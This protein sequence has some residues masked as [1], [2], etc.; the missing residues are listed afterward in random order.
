MK[1]SSSPWFLALLL[2]AACATPVAED[3]TPAP[4]PALDPAVPAAVAEERITADAV[5]EHIAILAADGMMGRDT[6]S[7]ELERAAEYL[8]D[9][10]REMGLE[11]AGD[12][13]DFQQ[14]WPFERLALDE[15]AS[16]ASVAID[17]ERRSWE[18]ARE[19]FAIPSPPVLVEGTPVY[20]SEAAAATRLPQ[21]AAGQPLIVGLPDGL[22]TGFALAVQGG[23]QARVSGIV[24]L[25]D[26]ETDAAAVHQIAEALEAGA[27]GEFPLPVLGLR[28][29]VGE[30]LLA[31]AG[32]DIRGGRDPPETRVLENVRVSMSFRF[33]E[34]VDEVPNV[35]A[36]LRGS[37][38][39]LADE[40]VVLTAHFDHVGVGPPDETGDTIY[41]GA[42]DNASGT[43]ALLQV[44]DAFAS[45]PEPPARSVLFLAVSGEEKGLLGSRHY[46]RNPTV[47]E[48]SI[49]A[50]INMDM[51]SRNAPD[52]VHAIGEEYTTL[53][54]LVH[55]VAR[56]HPELGLVLAPDPAPEEQ[57]FL[58]SDHY[59]F[60]EQGIPA[61]ML[62]TWLHDDYHQ[63][64]D[65][66]ERV[67]PDKAAR[68][69]RLAF[70]LAHRVASERDVPR[71]TEEGE[72]LLEALAGM[73]A[74][75]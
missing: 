12:D 29:D 72:R 48:G 35:V 66:P 34:Q 73:G 20:A 41:S 60:V 75:P 13:G 38:P 32:V 28:H 57:A 16:E 5:F 68:V 74:P 62:T 44:A 64:S 37:D 58:R 15:A 36:L 59:S 22:D 43:S 26:E 6:P 40:Y 33:E 2:L 8:A 70:L 47:P 45:L 39:D 50:N 69:A 11:P 55:E 1:P 52:S 10:F 3:P 9:A 51:V 24:L 63:P 31:S 46:A 17:G 7:P 71:W 27:A 18:Y 56:D 30:E 25:M 14:R 53:G 4:P 49:V 23:L 21:E 54:E 61:I 19:Y 67:D 65:T 42:D